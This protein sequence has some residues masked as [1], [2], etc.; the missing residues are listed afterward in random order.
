[1]LILVILILDGTFQPVLTVQIHHDPAL[2]ETVMAVCE[3]RFHDKTEIL[4]LRLH[5][6]DRCIVIAEMI[7]RALPQICVRFRNDLHCAVCDPEML[8]LSCPAKFCQVHY[9]SSLISA[10]HIYS[11]IPHLLLYNHVQSSHRS[12]SHT[13]SLLLRP[14]D[15][16]V[17]FQ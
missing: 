11:L 16:Q 4:F 13:T 14:D 6:K 5:L 17:Y 7:I 10:L 3:L 2:V 15:F 1:M 9:Y 8:R 12:A